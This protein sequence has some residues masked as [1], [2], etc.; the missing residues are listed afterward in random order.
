MS[1]STVDSEVNKVICEAVD[2][3]LEATTKI[4]VKAGNQGTIT[5]ELCNGCVKRF[6]DK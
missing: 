4:K 5:L 2:C 3:F 1:Q 6:Q